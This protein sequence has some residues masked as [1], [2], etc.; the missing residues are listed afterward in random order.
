MIKYI[1]RIC[2][3]VCLVSLLGACERRPL[4]D[5]NERVIVK[6]YLDVKTV[7]N[8]NTGI[9]NDRIPVPQISPSVIRVMFYDAFTGRL[10]TQAFISQKEI[11]EDGNEYFVGDVHVPSGTYDMLCYNFDTQ[12]VLVNG[13]NNFNTINAYTS[14]VSENYYARVFSSRGPGEIL[15]KVYYEPDHLVVAREHDLVIPDRSE[16]ITIYTEARTVIDT[17]Y[18]QVRLVNGQYAS[19]A[20][21]VLTDLSPSNKFALNER[22]FDEYAATFFE[23][24]RSVDARIRAVN[25]DVLCAT[26]NTFGKRPDDIAPIA[27]SKLYVTFNVVTVDGK[28]V[29]MTVDMD[30][31]FRSK[32]AIENHWLLIDK[33]IVIPEPDKP[34][35]PIGD[36]GMFDPNV[37]DWGREEG[38]IE[39]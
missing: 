35:P 15:P 1:V 39:L 9:Y 24:H 16:T 38:N 4:V 22:K 26:F 28:K 14:E 17:Y 8:V 10:A 19:D 11:D 36:G 37:E 2:I 12:S 33:E 20:I 6:L 31:I 27:G 13:E 34:D 3:V 30:E 7:L 29:E 21:A 18:I 5:P 23:M 32:E 25:Q